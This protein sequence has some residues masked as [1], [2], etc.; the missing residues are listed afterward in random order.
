MFN[1][2]SAGN[3]RIKLGDPQRLHVMPP[4]V[5]ETFDLDF[6]L[7]L[8]NDW[9]LIQSFISAKTLSCDEKKEKPF[10]PCSGWRYS[11][12]YKWKFIIYWISYYL[13]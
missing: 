4:Y 1:G 13:F 9:I 7:A 2:Q 12:I 3:P 11:P 6:F 5:V 8:I 10:K